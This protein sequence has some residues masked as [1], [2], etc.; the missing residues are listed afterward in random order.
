MKK[1]K[2]GIFS[3]VHATPEPVREALEIFSREA[4]DR[5]LCAGDIAGYGTQLEQTVELLIGCRC[6]AVRGNHDQWWLEGE[7]DWRT[8]PLAN[9]LH[10]LPMTYD[11]YS[12]G[13]KLHMV[14][15]S[16]SAS[17]MDG[18]RLLDEHAHLR[19]DQVEYWRQYLDNFDFDLLVVGHTHQVFAER[20]GRTLVVNPGSTLF[21]H[22]CAI[23]TL[24]E[25]SVRILP[26]GGK[27]PVLSWNW[28]MPW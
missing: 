25:M 22:T 9:Y 10:N 12:A 14:H 19:M 18:I 1:M 24:P 11:L 28:G 13:Q 27:T 8:G 21:N 17:L 3:D 7:G 5:V 6:L 16:P 4:V 15:G 26:L 23:L 20:L 2:I